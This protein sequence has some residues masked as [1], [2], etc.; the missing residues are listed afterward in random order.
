MDSF[1][2]YRKEQPQ[3][4]LYAA[5]LA[6]RGAFARRRISRGVTALFATVA[7]VSSPATAAPNLDWTKLRVGQQ[8]YLSAS[9]ESDNDPN[10]RPVCRTNAE[11]IAFFKM[12]IQDCPHRK[13]G[14]RVVVTQ[15]LPGLG[16]SHTSALDKSIP[17]VEIRSA[18]G[19]WTG[20]VQNISLEPIIPP[21]TRIRMKTAGNAVPSVYHDR[22]GAVHSD[23]PIGSPVTVKVLEQLPPSDGNC[24]I[25]VQALDGPKAG[26]VGWTCDHG[27]IN[28]TNR[29]FE[30]IS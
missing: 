12:Q 1:Q 21:G 17:F 14:T 10:T 9:L 27:T 5:G 8:A 26:I 6:I 4:R 19:R 23:I 25:K 15:I 29:E 20:W 11:Q 13:W 2:S 3:K 7:T 16:D 22:A 18:D 28:G 24:N 30:F